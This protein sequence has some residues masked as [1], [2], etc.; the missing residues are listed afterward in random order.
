MAN[1]AQRIE[2][3]EATQAN[4]SQTLEQLLWQVLYPGKPMPDKIRAGRS[5]TGNAE[6][7]ELLEQVH[8]KH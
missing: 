6:F 7:N 8:A 2:K 4:Q 3:L 1:I 5:G